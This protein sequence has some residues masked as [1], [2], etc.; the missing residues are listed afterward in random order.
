MLGIITSFNHYNSV[1]IANTFEEENTK[2][3][4]L[5]NFPKLIGGRHITLLC[6]PDPEHHCSSSKTDQAHLRADGV[7]TLLHPYCS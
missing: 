7:I 5:N 6:P 3:Q 2:I 4:S 1:K